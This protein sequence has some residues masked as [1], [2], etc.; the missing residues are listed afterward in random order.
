MRK[1]FILLFFI[2]SDCIFSSVAL[3]AQN[4]GS[5]KAS[6]FQYNKTSD[7]FYCFP[8]DFNQTDSQTEKYPLVIY[9]HGGGGYGKISGL[10]FLGYAADTGNSVAA[11]F[12][13]QYPAFVLVPQSKRGWNPDQIIPVVEEFKSTYPVDT[14]RIYLIGYSM[15]GSGSYS[16]LNGYYD[17][18]KTLLA[19]VI[20]LAGQSQTSLRD[21]IVSKTA[22]WLH[23]GL[24]DVP[25]RLSVMRE[26][27]EFLK[28]KK[29][30]ATESSE[31]IK[32]GDVSGTTTSLIINNKARIRKTEY[33]AVGHDIYRFPFEDDRLMLWLFQ[34]KL[35]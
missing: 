8:K 1:L 15:G 33:D 30:N 22:V 23:V 29:P 6:E 16:F 11:K 4:T 32:I 9:L 20:R 5:D 21:E 7:Y 18:N 31:N 14:T 35:E 25:A 28:M 17:H 3:Q 10:D 19:G 34:Q 24:D 2:A 26:A 27:Y 12:Q 13:S